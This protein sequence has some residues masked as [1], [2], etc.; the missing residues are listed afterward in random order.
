MPDN[1]ND[2]AG[3]I[4]WRW[5]AIDQAK[6]HLAEADRALDNLGR[7]LVRKAMLDHVTKAKREVA[8]ARKRLSG[9]KA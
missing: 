6:D 3:A 2:Y 5:Q 4:D 1:W 9:E 8:A 7:R